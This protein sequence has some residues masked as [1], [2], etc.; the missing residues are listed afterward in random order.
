M[1][2]LFARVTAGSRHRV[3]PREPA[4][5]RSDRLTVVLCQPGSVV[6]TSAGTLAV[7]CP[8]FGGAGILSDDWT[9]QLV[10][11]DICV[12]DVQ[13]QYDVVVS[14]RGACVAIVGTPQAWAAAGDKAISGDQSAGL[15]FPAVHRSRRPLCRQFLRFARQ[16][17]Q[18]PGT[19][20][21]R[22]LA[23]MLSALMADL[24]SGF[25]AMIARCPG[26]SPARK[27][28]VFLRLQ[29]VRNYISA[30]AHHDLDVASLAL[31][32][33]YSAGHF[34][35]TF[36]SVFGETPYSSISRFRVESAST[37]LLSSQLGIAD[38]AQSIGFQSRS[39]F[40]RAIKRHLGLSATKF[41]ARKRSRPSPL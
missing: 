32:A 28:A 30:C 23:H 1:K 3:D 34:I 10:R 4:T 25:A 21:G 35:T 2:F 13:A 27:K 8:I 20:N 24:Q 16:C 17:M 9:T 41:R 39:S 12:G 14:A 36:R 7:W 38:V 31:M 18:N 33:N 40:S 15:L 22:R 19:T 11:G 29:R 5:L 6:T 26:S 37:L